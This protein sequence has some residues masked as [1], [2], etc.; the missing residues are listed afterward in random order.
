MIPSGIGGFSDN[1]R[2]SIVIEREWVHIIM[3]FFHHDFV[4]KKNLKSFDF[5]NSQG[6]LE[7]LKVLIEQNNNHE[8]LPRPS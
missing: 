7:K 8:V 1:L 6:L 2:E 4:E 3:K 5:F